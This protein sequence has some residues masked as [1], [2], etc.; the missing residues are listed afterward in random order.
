MGHHLV[1]YSGKSQAKMD[2]GW[3]YPHDLGNLQQETHGFPCCH[4]HGHV[5]W[6]GVDGLQGVLRRLN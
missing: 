3:G 5:H 6:G 1:V 2:D 4:G